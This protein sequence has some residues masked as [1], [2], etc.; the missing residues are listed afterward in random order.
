[1]RALLAPHQA[2]EAP[3]L[4]G[5][6]I[7]LV[8]ITSP[9]VPILSKIGGTMALRITTLSI[10]TLRIMTFSSV[11]YADCHSADCHINA[12]YAECCYAECSDTLS[13]NH[14]I[15]QSHYCSLTLLSS[16]TIV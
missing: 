6:T 11:I 13:H 2:W 16:H 7:I 3:L 8:L 4:M 14:T 10:L 9:R 5:R 1:M 12:L 15:F